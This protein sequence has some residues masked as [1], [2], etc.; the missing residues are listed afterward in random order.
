MK[1]KVKIIKNPTTQYIIKR[2]QEIE[3]K[4]MEDAIKAYEILSKLK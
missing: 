1:H 3:L 4:E 2:Y